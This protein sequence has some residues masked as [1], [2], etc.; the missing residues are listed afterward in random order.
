DSRFY[1]SLLTSM[2]ADAARGGPSARLLEPY[3]PNLVDD[4]YALRVMGG[5]HFRVMRGAEPALAAHYPSTGGDADADAAWP[6]FRALLEEPRPELVAALR[7]PPQTNEVGRSASML[8]GFLAVAD[9]LGLPL[10]VL[11]LGAS[12]GLNLQF[13]RYRYG[14]GGSGF[15]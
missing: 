2:A 10:R 14:Q 15:G 5:I 12:A 8:V 11:E 4:A 1:D 6:R 7:H 9:E 3:A 13:D